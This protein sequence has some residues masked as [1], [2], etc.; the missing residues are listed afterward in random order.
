M[1][2]ELR[3]MTDSPEI[4]ERS[5]IRSSASPSRSTLARIGTHVVERQNR[6]RIPVWKNQIDGDAVR[7]DRPSDVLDVLFAEVL[8]PHAGQ[9]V[10]HLL[11]H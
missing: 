4:F 11:V 10:L 7:P 3:A 6:D 1:K 9:L 2:V 8:E 5:V